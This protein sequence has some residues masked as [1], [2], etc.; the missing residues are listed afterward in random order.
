MFCVLYSPSTVRLLAQSD[1]AVLKTLK[2]PGFAQWVVYLLIFLIVADR[3]K[4]W[5]TPA[6]REVS[7][8]LVTS[9]KQEI[10]LKSE[11]AELKKAFESFRETNHAEHHAA[12]TAGQQRVTNLAE[13][14]DAE[15]SELE[16]K[17]EALRE[18]IFEK[19]D[20]ITSTLS[21]KIDPLVTECARHS[22]A[23]P[24]IKENHERLEDDH[25][26]AVAK[27]HNRIDDCMK[28]RAGT[29]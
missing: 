21:A 9:P 18:S 1:D 7:G 12:I 22:T 3:L 23:I 14:M 10:A 29:K 17:L 24:M 8:E 11:V 2:E 27:I 28:L 15:T 19:L 25:R 26:Q 5:V 13:V 20:T 6:R 16:G 4:S